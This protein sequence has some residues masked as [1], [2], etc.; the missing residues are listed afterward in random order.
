MTELYKLHG[1]IKGHEIK[2]PDDRSVF[3]GRSIGDEATYIRFRNGEDFQ[4]IK[5]SPGAAEAL[6]T[7]LSRSPEEAGLVVTEITLPNVSYEGEIVWMPVE[8]NKE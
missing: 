6:K 1:D 2:L 5:L 4:R 7:L 8:E 3:V